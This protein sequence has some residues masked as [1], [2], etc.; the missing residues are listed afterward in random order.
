MS[1]GI[2]IKQLLEEASRA[3]YLL[4]KISDGDHKALENAGD[5]S[6]RLKDIIKRL[7]YDEA[8]FIEWLE[9]E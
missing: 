8:W 3:A 9:Q 7:G 4:Q 1:E 2:L 6:D 5:C